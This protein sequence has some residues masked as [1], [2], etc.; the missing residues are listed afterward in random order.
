MTTPWKRLNGREIALLRYLGTMASFCF[1]VSIGR[2]L[3]PVAASL[4]RRRIV[5]CWYRQ[6]P[7]CEPSL[8]GPYFSLTHHGA[9]LARA[10]LRPRASAAQQARS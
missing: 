4:C 8:Q 2:P 10:F 7:D 9:R 6:V 5:E 3:R 1:A